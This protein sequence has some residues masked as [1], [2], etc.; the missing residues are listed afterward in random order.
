MKQTKDT[1]TS[2]QVQEQTQHGGDATKD[3]NAEKSSHLSKNLPINSITKSLWYT[4]EK[5][6]LINEIHQLMINSFGAETYA[7]MYSSSHGYRYIELLNLQQLDGMKK[8]F[9]EVMKMKNMD[10]KE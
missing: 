1:N 9:E 7:A 5:E 4:K 8:G 2:N 3:C 6:K 10:A